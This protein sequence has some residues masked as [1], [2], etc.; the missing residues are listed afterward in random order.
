MCSLRQ[1]L[2]HAMKIGERTSTTAHPETI[3]ECL[4]VDSPAPA[5]S[6]R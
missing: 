4:I 5:G 6:V 3:A 2:G 1:L